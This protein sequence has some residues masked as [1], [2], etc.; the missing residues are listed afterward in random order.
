MVAFAV[1]AVAATILYE[2]ELSW[3]RG[4]AM[5]PHMPGRARHYSLSHTLW[6][7]VGVAENSRPEKRNI[8]SSRHAEIHRKYQFLGSFLL[9]VFSV[10]F[11]LLTTLLPF[12]CI[13]H[14]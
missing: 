1:Q 3:G 14:K 5:L 2:R 11:P 4:W 6:R 12:A 8:S 7:G 9:S 10:F 13:N